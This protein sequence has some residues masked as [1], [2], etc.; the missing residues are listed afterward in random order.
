MIIDKI[1]S[2]LPKNIIHKNYLKKY[3]GNDFVR[4]QNYTGFKKLRILKKNFA[5]KEI[6]VL[7][8]NTDPGYSNIIKI[9]KKLKK[10]KVIEN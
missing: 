1:Y 7:I 9:I 3:I 2:F 4:I 10:W 6:V 5:D 8:P